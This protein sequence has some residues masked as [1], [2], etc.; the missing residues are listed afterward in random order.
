[1]VR[2]SQDDFIHS[3]SALSAITPEPVVQGGCPIQLPLFCPAM[4]PGKEEVEA[5][6]LMTWQERLNKAICLHCPVSPSRVV[7][8]NKFGLQ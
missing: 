4:W 6:V 3:M 5:R 1:M 7:T 8:E 2:L